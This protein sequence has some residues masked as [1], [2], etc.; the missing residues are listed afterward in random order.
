MSEDEPQSLRS[1]FA[2][3]EEK[4]AALASIHDYSSPEYGE[5][6]SAAIKAYHECQRLVSDLSI[7]S[8]NLLR[9]SKTRCK[10]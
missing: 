7:F 3:A 5:T 10:D 2:Q 1:L 8:P 9:N 6:L 4:H